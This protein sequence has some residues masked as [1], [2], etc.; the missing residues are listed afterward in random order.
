MRNAVIPV[1]AIAFGLSSLVLARSAEP[2]A[3]S[4]PNTTGEAVDSNKAGLLVVPLANTAKT[5]TAAAMQIVG[6]AAGASAREFARIDSFYSTYGYVPG[7]SGNDKVTSYRAMWAAQGSADAWTDNTLFQ[8][9]TADS[10]NTHLAEDDYNMASGNR[11]GTAKWGD[12]L[13]GGTLA[14]GRPF[15]GTS[16]WGRMLT[17]VSTN[18]GTITGGY[19]CASAGSPFFQRCYVAAVGAIQSGFEDDSSAQV[20]FRAGGNNVDGVNLEHAVLS[21]AAVALGPKQS[22][23]GLDASGLRH[24][25]LRISN[26]TIQL[27]D[28]NSIVMVAGGSLQLPEVSKVAVSTPMA[29]HQA[30][31][32]D[33]ADHKLKRKDCAGHVVTIG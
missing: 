10:I 7:R 9:S 23:T 19:G 28:T 29:G 22:V 8:H 4:I 20:A 33:S 32:V 24:R 13:A 16:A 17:G 6:S 5:F 25:I 2:Q 1:L 3:R 26:R 12:G 30:L 15:G 31:F 14:N 27:G 18:G 21:G 11:Y